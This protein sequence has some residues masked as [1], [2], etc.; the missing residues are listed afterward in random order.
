VR[1]SYA[2]N[3]TRTA[4]ANPQRWSGSISY[5]AGPLYLAFAMDE[6]KDNPYTGTA[7]LKKQEGSALMGAFTFGR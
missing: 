4:A 3:E 7:L 2:V 5:T 6:M 1:L